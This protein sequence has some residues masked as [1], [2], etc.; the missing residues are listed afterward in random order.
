[1]NIDMPSRETEHMQRTTKATK[2]PNKAAP[3]SVENTSIVFD[4][5][6][7]P[8]LFLEPCAMILRQRC[9]CRR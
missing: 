7:C 9:R 5:P 8:M 6:V 1:M 3:E 2:L 4:E